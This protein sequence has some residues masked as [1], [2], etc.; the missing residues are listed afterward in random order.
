MAVIE[1]DKKAVILN[2]KNLIFNN[3]SITRYSISKLK[4][5]K[6]GEKRNTGKGQTLI[7]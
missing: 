6:S 2:F 7:L 3:Y 5:T 1:K 4:K